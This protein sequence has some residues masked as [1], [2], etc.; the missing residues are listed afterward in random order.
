MLSRIGVQTVLYLCV[1]ENSATFSLKS[2][3]VLMIELSCVEISVLLLGK[4]FN[5]ASFLSSLSTV[6]LPPPIFLIYCAG[7]KGGRPRNNNGREAKTLST[8]T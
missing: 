1:Q 5:V 8:G 3:P 4:I 7:S 2:F 6:I